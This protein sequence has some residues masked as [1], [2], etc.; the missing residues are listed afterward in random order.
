MPPAFDEKTW[1]DIGPCEV[2]FDGAVLGATV[3]NPDG[4]THGGT[5][6]MLTHEIRDALRDARGTK[7]YDRI[8]VGQDLRIQTNLTGLALDQLAS[9]IPGAVLTAGP[10]KKAM[11]LNNP[12]GTSMRANAGIL[13]LKPITGGVVSASADDWISIP[14]AY[15]DPSFELAFSNDDQKVYA[16]EFSTFENLTSGLVATFGLNTT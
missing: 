8:F 5:R 9:I 7:A 1:L 4:G 16:V 15:P 13:L 3:A 10:T 11:T 14:M 2:T 12:S 6:V